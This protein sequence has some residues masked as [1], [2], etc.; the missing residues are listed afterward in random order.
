[1]QDML[2][3]NPGFSPKIMKAFAD[4]GDV[5]TKG[6]ADYAAAVREGT[7]PTLENTFPK[8]DCSDEFLENLAESHPA[9]A[10]R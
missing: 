8:S 9:R 1:M 3:M 5:M 7:Y 10:D 4:A 2:G 6:F